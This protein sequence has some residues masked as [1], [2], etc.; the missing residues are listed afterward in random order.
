LIQDWWLCH[1]GY[2]ACPSNPRK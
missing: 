1:L 2:S